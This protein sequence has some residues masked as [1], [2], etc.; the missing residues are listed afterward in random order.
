MS[1]AASSRPDE[2]VYLG[3]SQSV[4]GFL[5][6]IIVA[7]IAGG[8]A[9]AVGLGTEFG[10]RI[11]ALGTEFGTRLGAGPLADRQVALLLGGLAALAAAC[12]ASV[13]YGWL[14]WVALSRD[15]IRWW[16]G[17][18]TYFRRWDD[19]AQVRHVTYQILRSAGP[20]VHWVEVHFHTRPHL[21]LS[22]SIV[23]GYEAL[24]ADIEARSTPQPFK[25]SAGRF[26]V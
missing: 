26:L 16:R 6:L 23:E 11:V 18:S 1:S 14:R 10:S 20:P 8:G 25:T 2:T 21:H 17:G 19:V 15:G 13:W 12:S 24:V 3:K 7:V 9:L 22:D 5:M 4:F